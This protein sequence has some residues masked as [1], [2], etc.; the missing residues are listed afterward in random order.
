MKQKEFEFFVEALK[1]LPSISNKS[2]KKI[3]YFF[4]EKDEQYCNEFI[5]RL[6]S[7]KTQMKFCVYCNNLTNNSIYCDICNHQDSRDNNKLCIVSTIEDLDKIEESQS[8]AGLYYVL[9]TEINAKD[10]QTSK[11]ID[12]NKLDKMINHFHIN[13]V[14]LA[15][16]MTIN[17][18]I[19][20]SYIKKFL[21]DQ[22][23]N[24]DIYRLSLGIPLNASIDYVD[25]E[26]L[27]YSIQNKKKIG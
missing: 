24:M 26:S 21:I 20:A 25:W 19:T 27:K 18:E 9:G 6:M 14:L 8:F 1:S 16:N 11:K 17:G 10:L 15:T 5:N 4:L 2:A 7:F 3:A 22:K 23:Y 12:L 13:E